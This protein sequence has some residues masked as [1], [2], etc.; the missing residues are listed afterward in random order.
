MNQFVLVLDSFSFTGVVKEP[1]ALTITTA[2]TDTTPTVPAIHNC[3]LFK[4]AFSKDA[5]KFFSG[6]I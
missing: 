3:F 1:K 2:I 4:E 6:P 5:N